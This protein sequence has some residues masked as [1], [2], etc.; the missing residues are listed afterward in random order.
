[1]MNWSPLV[2]LLAA[3]A[4]EAPVQA[5]FAAI[6]IAGGV[7]VVLFV[8]YDFLTRSGTIARATIK[9]AVRQPVFILLAIIGSLVIMANYWVPFFTLGDDTR[10]FIDCGLQ[11]I[12]ISSLLL[13]VWTASISVADEI[14]GKTAMTLLSKPINRRQ[15]VLGKYMGILQGALLLTVLLGTVLIAATYFKY[16]YDQKET[17]QEVAAYL[18]WNGWI[19]LLVPER[20]AAAAQILPALAL[21]AF[22]VAAMT[23]VSVAISTRAPMLVNMVTCFAIFVI[24]HLTP[25]LVQSSFEGGALV[26]VQ[27]VAQLLALV[28]PTLDHFNMSTAVST[29]AV[30]P[31]EYLVTT[32]LYCLAYSAAAVLLAFILFE[33]RDL[34]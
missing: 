20:F 10:V 6:A 27:F 17:G 12:L 1:M 5:P 24:G 7:A 26:F 30:I 4:V 8:L 34:A 22:E 14:E 11:T 21:I 23:A 31:L 2:P 18:N 25:V 28:L 9:E 13:A 19:P 33:D 32:G 29:G 3:E 16:G 15:F